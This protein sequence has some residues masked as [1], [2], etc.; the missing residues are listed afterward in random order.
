MLIVQAVLFGLFVGAFIIF[1]GFFLQQRYSFVRRRLQ[2][3]A[4][5]KADLLRPQMEEKP[6]L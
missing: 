5:P 3:Q 2:T 4:S 6:A 1:L